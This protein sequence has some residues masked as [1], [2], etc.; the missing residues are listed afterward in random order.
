VQ[1]LFVQLQNADEGL[2]T[3]LESELLVIK[4]HNFVIGCVLLIAA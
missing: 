3:K 2:A 1:L 4:K